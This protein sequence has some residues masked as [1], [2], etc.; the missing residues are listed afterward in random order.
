MEENRQMNVTS[1]QQLAEFAKGQLVELPPFGENQ[2]FVA[3]LKRPSMMALAKSGKIP[4]EL[5]NTAN[6]LFFDGAKKAALD[7]N[8]LQNM[9]NVMDVICDACFVE[10]TYSEIKGAGLELT[11]DQYMF[12]FNYSQTGVN[13]LKPFRQE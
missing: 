10:P 9:F 12:V 5:L 11:D 6:E 7:E 2:P 1:I 3:R 4:N 13:A 8:A